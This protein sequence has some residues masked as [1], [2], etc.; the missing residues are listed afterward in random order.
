MRD[1]AAAGAVDGVAL[2]EALAQRLDSVVP[3]PIRVW[4][5]KG[6]LW[7]NEPG[8][9][10][11]AS[12]AAQVHDADF[13]SLAH[14]VWGGLNFV[15]DAVVEYVHHGWPP[16]QPATSGEDDAGV[17]LPMPGYRVTQ[18][19]VHLW[20]GEESSPALIFEPIPLSEVIAPDSEP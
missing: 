17:D 2:A 19:E 20:Y 3:R 4:A 9:V 16:A 11:I 18:T 10:D 13:D 6:L 14:A 1:A 15:Q 7:T 12:V 8:A 5:D